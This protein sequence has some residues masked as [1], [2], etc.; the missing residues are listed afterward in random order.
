[1]SNR[2]IATVRGTRS[3]A[4]PGRVQTPVMAPEDREFLPAALEI[5]ETPPSPIAMALIKV[6]VV[7]IAIL[8]AVAYFGK[9]DIVAVAPGKIQPVGRIKII[10]PFE[11]GK[12]QA[13][14]VA[15]GQ[16]VAEGD[17]LVQLN[18]AEAMADQTASQEALGSWEAEAARRKAA[19]ETVRQGK[20]LEPITP[21]WPQGVSAEIIEREAR[22]Y[23]SDLGQLSSAI[24]GLEAKQREKA[25]Q[26]ARLRG[27]V[28]A[29]TEL[30]N[31]LQQRV[32]MRTTLVAKD[33]GSK[34]SL[35]DA[36]QTLQT[37]QATLADQ[38]GQLATEVAGLDVLPTEIKKT[39]DSFAA[40]NAQRLSE[41][42]RQADDIRQRLAKASARTGYTQL[43]SPIAGTVAG[44]SVTTVGQVVGAGTELMRIVPDGQS[45]EV[46]AYFKNSDIGFINADQTAVIK[47]DAFPFSR[48]GSIKGKVETVST[49][50]IPSPDATQTAG[51]PTRPLQSSGRLGTQPVANLVFPGTLTLEKFQMD[52]EGKTVPLI[53]GMTVSV[54][55]HTGKRRIL[56]Y[57]L[58]PLVDIGSRAIRE[59]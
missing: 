12:V 17:V 14:Y 5:L 44:L 20:L 1:M 31:T 35:I 30:V 45:L 32:D 48:Y 16:R 23:E 28:S 26:I 10:Q 40:D 49:D 52:V 18:D 47:V 15:N 54:E 41:A 59:R 19:I 56:D 25:A 21:V 50:A 38:N 29:Q 6:F 42:E 2:Q 4:V 43:V 7:A 51:D 24:A 13:L 39:I 22:I 55:V 8:I 58:S 53:S 33:A 37:E 34:A 9:L 36:K 11:T 27:M 46:E 57:F 3:V